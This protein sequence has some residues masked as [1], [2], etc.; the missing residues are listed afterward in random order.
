MVSEEVR[1]GTRMEALGLP[2][3]IA[4]YGGGGPS[5]T[6]IPRL[7]LMRWDEPSTPVH[8]VLEP[9]LCVVAQGRKQAILGKSLFEYDAGKYLVVSVDLPI[10]ANIVEASASTP[11]LAMSLSLDPAMLAAMVL[12]L[13]EVPSDGESQAGMAVSP[14]TA[15]L[16]DSVVRLLRLL[17]RPRDIPMLAPLAERE[18]I[19]RLLNGEQGTVLRQIALADSRPAQ[20][21]RATEWIRGMTRSRCGSRPRP[22]PANMSPSSFH[23]HFKAVTAMSPLQY[24]KLIRL[25][26]ARYLLLAQQADITR[27]GFAVGYE[28]PSQFSREYSRLFGAPPRRDAARLRSA[29]LD[30]LRLGQSL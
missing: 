14:L 16:L 10:H 26:E 24:Q 18:I 30:P 22:G 3:L 4:R 23:R 5:S 6:A 2:A 15:E 11:Y 20:I 27:I 8:S 12:E 1:A 28:N 25:Q 7:S 21:G 17:D 19:Y 29:A 13:P 9:M